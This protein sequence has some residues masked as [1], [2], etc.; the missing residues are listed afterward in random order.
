MRYTIFPGCLI[1]YRFPEYEKSARLVLKKLGLEL[2]DIDTFSCCGSQILESIDL[3]KIFLLNARNIA[4]AQKNDID[5]IITLCGS[6]THILKS[7]LKSYND[8]SIVDNLNQKLF[9]LNLELNDTHKIRVFHFFEFLNISNIFEKFKKYIIKKIK[10]NVV[11][12]N[13][14]MVFRPFRVSNLTLQDRKY[15]SKLLLECGLNVLHYKYTNRCCGGTLLAFE[16]SVARELGKLRYNALAQSKADMIVVSC[17]NCQLMYSVYQNLLNDQCIPS[18]F[19]PQILGLAMGF[20][21]NSVGLDR[22]INND[23]IEEIL[24]DYL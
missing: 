19:L 4:I 18:V 9:K 2:I 11:L 20:S 21:F 22:N 12:Q 5:T 13:P 23:N 24:K 17:P 7:C 6:C 10:I 16:E 8:I 15:I 1:S 14:C 3:N